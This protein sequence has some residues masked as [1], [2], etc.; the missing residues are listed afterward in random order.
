M[1]QPILTKFSVRVPYHI[2]LKVMG[3]VKPAKCGGIVILKGRGGSA[4][5]T[6]YGSEGCSPLTLCTP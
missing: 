5:A 1:V 4:A 3:A 2:G 6:P